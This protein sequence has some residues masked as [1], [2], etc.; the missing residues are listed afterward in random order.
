MRARAAVVGLAALGTLAGPASGQRFTGELAFS[1]AEHRVDVG[2]GVERSSGSLFGA[3]ARVTVAGR[4]SAGVDLLAGVLT[5]RNGGPDRSVGQ[6]RATLGFRALSWLNFEAGFGARS[7]SAAIARQRWTAASLGIE[8]TL[9]FADGYFEG[10]GRMALVP[11]AAV[12]DLDSPNPGVVAAVGVR[13]RA[14]P[15]S[16]SMLYGVERYDFPAVAGVIR[17][18]RL[19]TLTFQ[20]T[21]S[22]AG[23]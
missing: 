13:F 10:V 1:A 12:T 15:T 8:G 22:P 11:S 18:E 2:A 16:I 9:R 6:L 23:R 4:W 20:A 21:W 7:Y 17:R 3:G 5:A 19:S 14:R